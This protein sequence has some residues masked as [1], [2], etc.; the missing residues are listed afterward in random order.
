MQR[1]V[2]LDE[3]LV[4]GLLRLCDGTRD[5]QSLLA[6][7]SHHDPNVND[8]VLQQH[9]AWLALVGLMEA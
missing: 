7:L 1:R 8:D 2:G 6:E 3:P 5:R 9:M 4:L